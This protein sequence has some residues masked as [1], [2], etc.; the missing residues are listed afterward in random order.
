VKI[1]A[2][3][4]TV[5]L[6]EPLPLTVGVYYASDLRD[7]E[8]A[9]GQ[10]YFFD[11]F[12]IR[13]GPPS[14]E[15]FDLLSAGLFA[16]TTPTPSRPSVEHPAPIDVIEIGLDAF[17]G[18]EGRWPIRATTTTVNLAYRVALW[19]PR[20][21]RL[22]AWTSAGA[23]TATEIGSG[24]VPVAPLPQEPESHHLATLTM[25][26]MRK[27]AADFV[28]AFHARPDVKAWLESRGIRAESRR[29][30]GALARE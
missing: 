23:G 24:I 29:P 18:C 26:A 4:R 20:G 6:V 7:H 2:P 8:C 30:R 15:L 16:R 3:I 22:A 1:G 17:S 11:R 12:V 5:P 25:I 10:D 28:R 14:V 27:A 21:A 19:D 13:L 9:A